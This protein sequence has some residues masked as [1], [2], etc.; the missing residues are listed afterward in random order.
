MV[1]N[2]MKKISILK[3]VSL[4][5]VFAVM[6]YFLHI[7]FGTIFYEGYNSFAQ[8]ISDLTSESSPSKNIARTFSILYGIFSVIF[9]LVFLFYFKGRINKIVT[10]ALFVYCSMN[11]VSFI[12]YSFFPLSE[13]GFAGT[14]Q[15]I[16]HIIVTMIV[17]IFTII[18]LILYGIGFLRIN[19]Y[20]YIGV[21]SI[22]SLILLLTG[23]MLINILP[24]EYFGLA[25]RINV[26]TT[27]IYTGVLSF[28][29]NRYLY[30]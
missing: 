19:Y 28:W 5:G 17:V 30:K 14:F 22:F 12:G 9:S 18:S 7:L 2:L 23:A 3:L 6:F 21:V 26:F 27:V 11:I 10:V 15:D 4:F 16:M 8:A 24:G 25:Q 29:M 20:K 13:A 1:N